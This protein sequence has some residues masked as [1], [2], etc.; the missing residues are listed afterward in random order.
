MLAIPPGTPIADEGAHPDLSHVDPEL[1]AA[2]LQILSQP[3]APM[4]RAN[5]SE[6]RGLWVP[7]PL[8]PAPEV[9]LL[10]TPGP[11]GAPDVRVEL[12]GTE[13]TGQPRPAILHIH[14]GGF[15][16]G[17]AR[18]LTAFCQQLAS[19]FDCVVVNVDYRLAPEIP[20]PGAVEDNYAALSWLHRDARRLGVD[21]QRIV[22]MGESAGGGHA[23]ILTLLARDRGEVPVRSQI[24]LYPMLDDRT[25]ATRAPP[26]HIGT[27]GWGA[28]A[29]RFG[30][31][32]FLGGAAGR[33]RI[34]AGASPARVADLSRLPPTF[35]GVGDIDLFVEESFDYAR[36]LVL[37]GVP[38]ELVVVPGAFHA[39]DFVAPEARVSRDFTRAWKA[40]LKTAFAA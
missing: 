5:L 29:N 11:R 35:I 18:N 27:I 36:R 10:T 26:S 4:T 21:P 31:D 20:Y 1:R 6:I 23:A 16:S 38:T 39:F 28:A 3:S 30:W 12:I 2:A 34:P 33:A 24:L 15:V 13:P 22:V 14:G 17:K 19:E 8:L 37:A 9:K 7:P 40:A 32:S 25:G